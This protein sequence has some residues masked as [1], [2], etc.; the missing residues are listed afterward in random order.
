MQ[1]SKDWKKKTGKKRC[2][3]YGRLLQLKPFLD[4]DMFVYIQAKGAGTFQ[5]RL[6][7]KT[8]KKWE[9]AFQFP[10]PDH[11]ENFSWGVG[12]H[13]VVGRNRILSRPKEEYEKMFR[14]ASGSGN[15]TDR[16]IAGT[17]GETDSKRLVGTYWDIVAYKTIGI[18]LSSPNFFWD[19]IFLGPKFEDTLAR[20]HGFWSFCGM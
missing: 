20:V 16:K 9:L 17:Q 15:Y 14:F 8:K 1:N 4:E 18:H 12:P 7:R 11:V 3:N 13:F 10:Y 19:T 5:K 2:T 6:K